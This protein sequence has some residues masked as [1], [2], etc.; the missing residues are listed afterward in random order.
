VGS[1]YNDDFREMLYIL[2]CNWFSPQMVSS[3][4]VSQNQQPKGKPTKE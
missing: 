3:F 4:V 1:R 2:A